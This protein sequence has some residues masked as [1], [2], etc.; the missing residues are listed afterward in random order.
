MSIAAA[1]L[2]LLR[3]LA[4]TAVILNVLLVVTGGAVRLTGSG[5][6]CP[7]WP[8]CTSDSLI[9]TPELGVHGVIEFGNRLLGVGLELVGIALLITVLRLRGRVPASWRWLAAVQALVVPAQAVIGGLLVLS[10][11]NPYLRAL[12]FLVSFPIM[13]AAVVLLRRVVDGPGTMRPIVGQQLRW[14]TL[15]MVA[16]SSAVVVLGALV[17]GTGPHSGDP[18]ARRL[19]WNPVVLTQVHANVVYVL[20]AFVVATAVTTRITRCPSG[21]RRTLI[22]L[23]VLL[24][25]QGGLGY[26]QYYLGAPPV[27]VAMHMLGS[28]LVFVTA[29]WAHA[30]TTGPDPDLPQ[31]RVIQNPVGLTRTAER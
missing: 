17:T 9:T 2:V 6:G 28:A 20:V 16:I 3:R 10:G 7:T 19:P 26:A 11:L 8:R 22:A 27:L 25:A 18:T 1:P 15:T 13:L 21:V 30:S 24:V 23:I 31:S 14:M 12:H 4:A 5:L 29:V